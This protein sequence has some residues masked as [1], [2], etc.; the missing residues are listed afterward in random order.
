MTIEASPL[1]FPRQVPAVYRVRVG[2]ILVT[3][4]SDGYVKGGEAI[5]RNVDLDAA[6]ALLHAAH[7][8][9]AVV[10]ISA[11]IIQHAG[12]TMLVDTGA[13][14]YMGRNAGFLASNLDAAGIAG[15]D[16]GTIF[17]THIHPDHVGGLTDRVE[18]K[19]HFP[20]AELAVSRHEYAYWMDDTRMER[21]S[22]G[23]RALFFECP[24]QQLAPYR[25]RLRLL[26]GGEIFPGVTMLKAPGHTPGHA[27]CLIN[28]GA[29]TLLIWGDTVHVPEVQSTL[30]HAG[31]VFDVDPQGAADTR[32]RVFDMAATDGIPVMGMHLGFPGLVHLDRG[33]EGYR[34]TPSPWRHVL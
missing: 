13:G 14:S 15:S 18:G 33:A 19:A 11:F 25:N 28:S 24:R 27:M 34:L 26:D 3:A 5:L 31:V 20:N 32:R 16:I 10:E 6:K 1:A 8:S 29:D 21:A 23:D 12:H 4:L 7:R 30:P 2:D 22:A 9:P 17:L